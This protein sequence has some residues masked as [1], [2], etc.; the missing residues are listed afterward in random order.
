MQ[1]A[2]RWLDRNLSRLEMV[3]SVTIIMLFVG[4][5]MQHMLIVFARAERSMVDRT[6]ININTA[7]KYRAVF[8]LMR[9]DYGDLAKMESTN[10]MAV[11]E[12]EQ[13]DNDS[14]PR[15]V[16]PESGIA[17][18]SRPANY[19]GEFAN[20]D[21]AAEPRGVWYYDKDG[22]Q[23]VYIVR[24]TEFFSSDLPGVPRL[25]FR[26]KIDYID[27]DGNGKFDPPVDKYRS[28]QLQSMDKYEWAI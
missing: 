22:H 16:Q 24:Y 11:T 6:V 25:R 14:T 12:M 21:P 18:F 8:D 7:L 17:G 9:S 10:P 23:L 28:V 15:R 2:P 3:V 13:P 5:F 26:V 1:L 19:I 4:A 20:P 27:N